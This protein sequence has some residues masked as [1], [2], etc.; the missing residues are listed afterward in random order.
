[1]DV[2][3]GVFGGLKRKLIEGRI[4]GE[5]SDLLVRVKSRLEGGDPPP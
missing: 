3:G 5:S 1:V 2:L 4:K